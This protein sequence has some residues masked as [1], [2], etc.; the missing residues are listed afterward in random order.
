MAT[1][2]GQVEGRAETAA[3]RTGSHH[4]GIKAS[5]QSYDGS[6]ITRLWYSKDNELMCGIEYSNDT[7][8]GW[9]ARTLFRGKFDD[10][11]KVFENQE[12]V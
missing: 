5:V 2:Y 6:I 3:S 7:S 1:F 11:I 8:S 9:G 12:G 4:S 10:F